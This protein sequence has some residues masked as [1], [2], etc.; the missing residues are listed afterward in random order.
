MANGLFSNEEL[1]DSM[2][3]DCNKAVSAIAGGNGIV[4]CRIMVDLV[5]RLANLKEGIRN[6]LKNRDETINML[7][8]RLQNTDMAVQSVDISEILRQKKEGA[9][10]G[11]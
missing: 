5:T 6:E 9:T 2:I 10:D 11:K 4:W 8:D 1:I 7:T 3:V